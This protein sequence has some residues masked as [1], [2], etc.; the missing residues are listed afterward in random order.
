M[1]HEPERLTDHLGTLR[2]PHETVERYIREGVYRDTGW[3]CTQVLY[4]DMYWHERVKVDAV[5]KTR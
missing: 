2:I 1:K 3:R 4:T 5:V